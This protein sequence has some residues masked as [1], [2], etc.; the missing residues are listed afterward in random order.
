M[1]ALKIILATFLVLTFA[2]PLFAQE[3][4]A[5]VTEKPVTVVATEVDVAP[6]VTEVPGV[7]VE[8]GG[9]VIIN[10][11][12]VDEDDAAEQTSNNAFSLA[13]LLVIA[14]SV[15]VGLRMVLA[16]LKEGLAKV[17]SSVFV[18]SGLEAAA[19]RAPAALA[20]QIKGAGDDLVDIGQLVK[21]GIQEA[22]DD[23]PFA[24]R[25][26]LDQQTTKPVQPPPEE[27]QG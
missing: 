22:F 24:A 26:I 17:F 3:S 8:D 9:T 19:H 11:T 4:T 7:V 13:S 20:G 27:P 16:A 10:E 1:K 15:L 14:G 23:M 21:K 12:P 25:Q 5:E 2:L 6:E 18:M